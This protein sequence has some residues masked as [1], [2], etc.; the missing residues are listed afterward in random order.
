MISIIPKVFKSYGRLSKAGIVVFALLTAGSAYILSLSAFSEFSLEAFSALLLGLYF[1]FSGGFILNQA[2]EW[3]LDQKMRRTKS[4][5]IPSG[6]LSPARAYILSA[7]FLL[8]GLALLLALKPLAGFLAFFALAL[9]NGFYTLVWKKKLKYGAVLGALP[10]ALPPVIGYSLEGNSLFDSQCL[11]L[12]LLLF[13]WQM[14]HFWS[15][16]MRYREDYKKAGIPA[17]PVLE[18]RA[19]TLFHIGLYMLAY[20]GMALISPLFLK[21]GLMYIIA[22]VPLAAI[23]LY[24]FYKYFYSSERW[25]KFFLWV[26]ASIIIYFAVPVM[27][28][29]IFDYFS[30]HLAGL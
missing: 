18:G 29:W 4:R 3:R 13:F 24:Q 8:F 1:V 16:A 5:P 20:I 19:K 14:P 6:K 12:F 2:Q 11:Y 10:G 25:L 28:K 9:Y 26:N 27:D 7:L 17:L 21:T 23:L 30:L 15:L 22:L